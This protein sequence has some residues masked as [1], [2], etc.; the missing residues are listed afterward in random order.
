MTTV[1]DQVAA[2]AARA[3]HATAAVGERSY[4]YRGLLEHAE[5]LAA[6]LREA[7]PG[8]SLVALETTSPVSGAIAVLAGARA[9]RALVPMNPDSPPGH[10]DR[11]LADARPAAVLRSAQEAVFTVGSPAGAGAPDAGGID[12]HRAAYV[13]FTSGSTGR[14]KGVVVGHE[15]LAARIRALANVPGMGEGESV[16]AMT[17]LSFDIS[18]AELLVPLT[19]GARFVAVP[20]EVR[21]DPDLF[22]EFVERHRPDVIQATPSFW[23]LLLAAGERSAGHAA[24]V[25]CGGEALTPALA[26]A[27]LA[28]H[29]E[30]WNLY[31]PTEA[32]IWAGAARVDDPAAVSLG[33]P[34]PGSGWFLD[35][36]EIVLHGE[37][38]AEGY[39][40]QEDV[41]A[42]R[43]PVLDTPAGRARTYRTGDRGRTAPGG[44]LEYLGRVDWQVKLRGHRIEL[45]EV[46]SVLEEHPAVSEA[47]AVVQHADRPERA[48]IAAH[49]V[50]AA[51]VT[52]PELAAWIRGR[53]PAPYCPGR[54]HLVPA[55]PRNTSGKVDRTALAGGATGG[56]AP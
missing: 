21:A 24:R 19:V 17:A 45:G 28:R 30:L 52:A 22:E 38:L 10:R 18:L 34:L 26:T 51:E 20:G 31:G 46:E 47:V 27:L 6:T 44:A 11:I 2:Q 35:D 49:V 41:T 4:T 39:L 42:E 9:G 53:L 12:L 3:P 36:G 13:M 33:E 48:F 50:P 55:L 37:G 29:K 23:R 14:P 56:G 25:W 40:G 16:L 54:I 7:A 43:F 15:A 1:W 8:G 32:T 5:A